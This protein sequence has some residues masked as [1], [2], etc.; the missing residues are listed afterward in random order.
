MTPLMVEKSPFVRAGG[1]A[2]LASEAFPSD[3]SQPRRTIES[4]TVSQELY[5]YY[6]AGVVLQK[7]KQKTYTTDSNVPRETPTA[8]SLVKVLSRMM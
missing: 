5:Y 3:S 6:L 2:V 7:K 1:E 4:L 8:M